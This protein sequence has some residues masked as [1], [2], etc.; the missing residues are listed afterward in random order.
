SN[1]PVPQFGCRGNLPTC[2]SCRQVSTAR[3]PTSPSGEAGL[4]T[5]Q[6]EAG[7]SFVVRFRP[8]RAGKNVSAVSLLLEQ[9]SGLGF[10]LTSTLIA[11]L[12]AI[13]RFGLP[14]NRNTAALRLN[15]QPISPAIQKNTSAPDAMNTGFAECKSITIGGE[16][17]RQ[18]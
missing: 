7:L 9:T 4:R 8:G 5:P 18:R 1:A 3:C 15:L 10:S 6:G 17:R 13:P 14:N 12:P 2:I 16:I 11:P